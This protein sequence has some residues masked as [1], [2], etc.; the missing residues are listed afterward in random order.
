MSRALALPFLAGVVYVMVSGRVQLRY[1]QED[2]RTEPEHRWPRLHG[3]SLR[4]QGTRF[5]VSVQL[6]GFAK[7]K[8]FQKSKT[9]LDRAHPTHSPPSKIFFLE[10]HN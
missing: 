1:S 8:K 10:T 9:N 7:L 2:Q 5:S 3:S 6:R 4:R